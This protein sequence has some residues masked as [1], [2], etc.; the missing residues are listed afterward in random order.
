VTTRV[1]PDVIASTT[2]SAHTPMREAPVIGSN[3]CPSMDGA[4][5]MYGFVPPATL[6]IVSASAASAAFRMRSR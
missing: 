6:V 1:V 5:S 3:S 2:R 4:D